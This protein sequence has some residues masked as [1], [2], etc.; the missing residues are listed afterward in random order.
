MTQVVLTSSDLQNLADKIKIWG[1]ELGFQQIGITHIELD[2]HETRL[3]EWLAKGYHGSMEYMAA[4]DNM[5]SRPADLLPGTMRVISARMDYL[6]ADARIKEQLQDKTLAYVSRYAL[7]RDYHKVIRK[8]FI[9][10]EV[11]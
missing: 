7:G 10:L 6:P 3:K 4:H 1:R 11:I 9:V 5:R 8:H 2:E